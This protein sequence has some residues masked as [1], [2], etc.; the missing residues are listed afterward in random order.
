MKKW[1]EPPSIL[2]HGEWLMVGQVSRTWNRTGRWV[3]TRL[4]GDK[5]VCGWISGNKHGM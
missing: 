5:E 1:P 4:F 2:T 3:V